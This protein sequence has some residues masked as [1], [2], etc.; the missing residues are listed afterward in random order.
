MK[1]APSFSLYLNFLG[2]K[3]QLKQQ[4][5]SLKVFILKI[6]KEYSGLLSALH[7][8]YLGLSF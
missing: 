7:A 4:F 2:L 5:S 1:I 8:I 6:F 3:F